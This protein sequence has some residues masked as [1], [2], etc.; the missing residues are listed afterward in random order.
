MAFETPNREADRTHAESQEKEKP[1]NQKGEEELVRKKRKV[2][3]KSTETY[4]NEP[5]INGNRVKSY[6]IRIV[7]WL[8]E[9]VSYFALFCPN[10]LWRTGDL[11]HLN[12]RSKSKRQAWLVTQVVHPDCVTM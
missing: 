4:V 7:K 8:S 1:R 3:Q 9:L 12:G 2:S 5:A 6:L 10:E 11:C